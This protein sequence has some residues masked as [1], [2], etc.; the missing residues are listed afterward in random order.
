MGGSLIDKLVTYISNNGITTI[1]EIKA[2]YTISSLYPCMHITS[3]IDQLITVCLDITYC[4]KNVYSIV[5][6]P[7]GTILRCSM[8]TGTSY[9]TVYYPFN[10]NV[11]GSIRV[12]KNL[13]HYTY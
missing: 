4:N 10:G 9:N 8:K 5:E 6:I 13:E 12:P 2:Y 11:D 1:P 3:V 7:I